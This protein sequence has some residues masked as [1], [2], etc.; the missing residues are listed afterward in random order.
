MYSMHLSDVSY[1]TNLFRMWW[2]EELELVM[3]QVMSISERVAPKRRIRLNMIADI[4]CVLLENTIAETERSSN[5]SILWCVDKIQKM[6]VT[7]KCGAFLSLR[8]I[9]YLFCNS[10]HA[11]PFSVSVKKWF[12]NQSIICLI[13]LFVLIHT[14]GR[15]TLYKPN[16]PQLLS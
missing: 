15:S 13:L 1:F 14:W 10:S 6:R 12:D 8:R 7:V 9:Q 5:W 11:L 4:I 3:S 16:T 2:K